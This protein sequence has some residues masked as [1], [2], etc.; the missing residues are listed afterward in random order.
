[1]HSAQS[2]NYFSWLLRLWRDGPGSPW[3]ASLYNPH[4]GE[5]RHFGTL[6]QLLAFLEAQTGH[7]FVEP[8]ED[9]VSGLFE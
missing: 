4:S 5:Q 2:G 1:M 6:S 7:T 9:G 8:P 3:R